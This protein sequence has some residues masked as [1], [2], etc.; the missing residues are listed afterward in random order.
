MR[1]CAR[2]GDKVSGTCSGFGHPA[3][4]STGGT[5]V[6]ASTDVVAND[7][8]VARIGDRVQLDC[9]SAHFAVIVGSSTDVKSNRDNARLGD[10]VSGE[11]VSFSGE[12]VT[13]STNVFV[14]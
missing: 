4:L 3:N 6:T 11:N 5:I 13:A 10:L 7:R 2:L 9:N 12:I 1:G 8:G 14:N